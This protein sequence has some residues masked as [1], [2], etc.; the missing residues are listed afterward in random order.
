MDTICSLFFVTIQLDVVLCIA[1]ESSGSINQTEALN[2]LSEF[3]RENGVVLT[4]DEAMLTTG[5]R[6]GM[7][8]FAGISYG[9]DM[10]EMPLYTEGLPASSHNLFAVCDFRSLLVDPDAAEYL[11]KKIKLP[12]QEIGA[13][14]LMG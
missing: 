11:P 5:H 2:Q 14:V 12:S 7:S 6:G 9:S 3:T 13:M 4:L 10:R 8:A 1:M